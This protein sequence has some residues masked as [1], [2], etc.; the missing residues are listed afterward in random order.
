MEQR[1]KEIL[2]ELG[3]DILRELNIETVQPYLSK[4]G[5]TTPEELDVL[6]ND[7][8]TSAFKT[9]KLIYAWLPLKGNNSLSKFIEALKESSEGTNHSDLAARLQAKRT[10]GTVPQCSRDLNFVQYLYVYCKLIAIS[11]LIAQ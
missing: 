8:K 6:L 1:D 9:K 11:N 4:H 7:S 10:E 2:N 5:L 3:P